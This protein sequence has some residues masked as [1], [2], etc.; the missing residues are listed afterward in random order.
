M[1]LQVNSLAT[2]DTS[3]CKSLMPLQADHTYLRSLGSTW[4]LPFQSHLA[5][6]WAQTLR[7]CAEYS[8]P[9]S[10]AGLEVSVG[11]EPGLGNIRPSKYFR[12]LLYSNI[13]S[14]VGGQ[15]DE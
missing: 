5:Q 12:F 4:P 6:G 1:A 7:K 3:P 9:L 8:W 15:V 11:R 13:K 2:C 10:N 14:L